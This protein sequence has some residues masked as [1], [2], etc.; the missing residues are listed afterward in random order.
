[1]LFYWINIFTNKRSLTNLYL[2]YFFFLCVN[3]MPTQ[4]ATFVCR[5]CYS[6]NHALY[7]V[8]LYSISLTE[9]LVM[10]ANQNCAGIVDGHVDLLKLILPITSSTTQLT[11]EQHQLTPS[12]SPERDFLVTDNPPEI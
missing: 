1:M 7:P 3:S 6:R 11:Y 8:R 10:C 2:F 5:F 4:P 9:G 12:Y